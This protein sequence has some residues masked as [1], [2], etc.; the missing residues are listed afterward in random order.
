MTLALKF[1]K[2]SRGYTTFAPSPA[3]DIRNA[4]LTANVASSITVP[5]VTDWYTVAFRYEPGVTFWVDVTG[6]TASPPAGST[7][8]AAT[9][10]LNPGSYLLAGGTNISVL[11]EETTGEVEVSLWQGG[12]TA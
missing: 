6:A 7:F 3:T 10:A 2:D 8:A 1:S 11:T 4:T 12:D 5:S 9:S